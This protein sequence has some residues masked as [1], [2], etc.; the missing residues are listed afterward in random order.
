MNKSKSAFTP[1][2]ASDLRATSL[3]ASPPFGNNNNKTTPATSATKRKS[4]R[5]TPNTSHAYSLAL[6]PSRTITESLTAMVSTTAHQLDEIWDEVGY[7]SED[8]TSQLSD[9]M[10]KFRDLCEAKLAEEQGVA[11]TFRHTISETKAEIVSTSN[12][13]QIPIDERLFDSSH[14][15]KQTTLTDELAILEATLEGLREAAAVAT[16]DLE[17]SR[18]FLVDAHEMLG[19]PL[20]DEWKE[21]TND[22]TV[23]RRKRAQQKVEEMKE[24][25]AT[26]S[27]AV[28]QLLRDCQH[29]MKELRMEAADSSSKLDRQIAGS[30][31]RKENGSYAMVSN[32][33]SDT[34]TGISASALE[35]LT[36]RVAALNTEKRRRTA[37]LEEMGA[38]IMTLWEKLRVSEEEQR[39]FS[40]SIQGLGLDTIEQGE[41]ELRRLQTLKTEMLGKLVL[42]SRE[43]IV[44]L[45]NDMNA[46]EEYRASFEAFDVD[47]ESEFTEELLEAHEKYVDHLKAQLEEMKPILRIIER[48]DVILRERKEYQELQKDS[49][50]LKQRGAALTKQLMEEEKM[51]RR[52]KRELPKL[53]ALLEEKLQ[54]WKENHGEEFQLHGQ[55]YSEI[56]ERQEEEWANYKNSLS[57]QKKKKQEEKSFSENRFAPLTRKTS[58]SRPFGDASSRE[59]SRS[60]S[61]ARGR[62]FDRTQKSRSN[63]TSTT[64]ARSNSRARAY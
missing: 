48:R 62:E 5:R 33:A 16:R 23:D 12:A 25:I 41:A 19:L 2:N 49:D 59:N 1:V 11:E 38:K 15:G 56:M 46:S 9:L 51:A 3:L 60:S 50:R 10:V 39:A 24:E 8:R 7:S 20:D 28:I 21:I 40:E 36:G 58:S 45:W 29:L 52:I 55:G 13:L 26:R 37:K 14:N 54:E 30:L 6:T 27:S 43:A 61:R 31:E 35:D 42:E 17:E 4:T 22:L 34:C 64:R 32:F 44:C 57:L 47:D 53:T 63:A 18:D